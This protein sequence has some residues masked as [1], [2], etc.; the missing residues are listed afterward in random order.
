MVTETEKIQLESSDLEKIQKFRNDYS[1]IT[2]K[3]ADVEVELIFLENQ[4]EN[5]E[6]FK[7]KL[8]NQ[9]LELRDL[10][11]KLATELREKYGEG[12]F[13]INTGIFTPKQ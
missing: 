10:E 13:D 3:L 2:T 9:L 5:I 4:K 7:S 6:N 12:E 11:I 1:E 8:R